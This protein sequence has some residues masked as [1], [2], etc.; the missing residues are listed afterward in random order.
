MLFRSL[1]STGT[2]QTFTLFGGDVAIQ[3]FTVKTGE[4]RLVRE[5]GTARVWLPKAGAVTLELKLLARLEGDVTKRRLTFGLPPALASQFTAVIEEP[6]ADVEF[7]TAVAFKRTPAG[8]QT[9]VEAIIGSTDRVDLAWTPRL[10][11]IAEMDAT[12]F[13]QTATLVT[14]GGGVVN[15][16]AFV[17]YQIA[18]GELKQ[19]KVRLPAGQRLLRVEEIGRAHV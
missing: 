2:N 15:A 7:P 16:R 11:R 10:K 4:A 19:A 14:V 18:Q 3:S 12:V 1:S 9:R 6:D 17:D 5:G 13:A 8:K